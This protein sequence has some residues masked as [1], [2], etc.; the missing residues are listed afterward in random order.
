MVR[1]DQVHKLENV[2]SRFLLFSSQL[3]KNT[4]TNALT[5]LVR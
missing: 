3:K 5:V 2:I 4:F 1:T